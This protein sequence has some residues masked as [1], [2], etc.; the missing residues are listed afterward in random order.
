NVTKIVVGKPTHPRWRDKL[1]G[2]VLDQLVRG[3]GDVDVYV[4]TGDVEGET[5]QPRPQAGRA[6][7]AR[8]YVGAALVAGLATLVSFPVFR[9]L[10]LTDVAMVFLLGVAI[11][12]SRYGRGP[13]IL[14]SFLSIALFDFFFVPPRFTFAVSDVG[15]ALTFVVM[16]AIALLISGLT[17][18]IRAQAETARERER[19]TSALYAMS[20]EFAGA[21]TERDV[22]GAAEKHWADTFQ[23]AVT[24]L[25]P[26]AE[27][28]LRPTRAQVALA[29]KERSVAE[30]V[31]RNGKPA[32]VGTDTLPAAAA[33]YFPLVTSARRIGVMSLSGDVRCFED[34]AQRR[35]LEAFAGQ[36]ALALERAQLSGQ[37]ERAKIEIEAERLRT[38]LLSSLSHDLRTPLGAIT[39]A[40]TTLL[41]QSAALAP[42]ARKD[43]L[44]TILGESRRMNRLIANLL[45]MVRLE[46]GALEVQREWQPLEE[47]VAGALMRLAD[48]LKDRRVEVHLPP[49]L[50]LVPVD[51]VLMEQ[52]FVNLLENAAK[53]TPAGTPIDVTAAARDG[54]VLVEV[55]D[56]GPG[57]PP[58][59]E[60]RIFAKF[61]RLPASEGA[62]GVGLG[63]AIV[64][65]I[66][67]AHGGRMW[68]E[69]RPG[70]GAAFRFTLPIG[71]GPPEPVPAADEAAEGRD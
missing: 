3:S 18:R 71:G 39:G 29:E 61:Y 19:H 27:G 60:E 52:V 41:E 58:G 15:Y 47:P 37:A 5:A 16:L 26:D 56:R 6:A 4:I 13:T 20:R 36:T 46:S 62:S 59:E 66:I 34:S 70:G 10:S 1:Y 22:I 31:H 14:A 55:A 38:S 28:R 21:R 42:A 11:V 53:H 17:L 35:L 25:L 48:V 65:G 24:L 40:A 2:S 67:T 45:D 68:V 43:L 54:E 33:F 50:P 44:E 23:A 32:G 12:A 49:D 9:F 69:Q 63:L 7:P 8:E 30:W 57:I 51:A 64:R